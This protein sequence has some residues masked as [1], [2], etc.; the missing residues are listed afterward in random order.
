MSY[1]EIS[2]TEKNIEDSY[3][4]AIS[5][6]NNEELST[7]HEV[8]YSDSNKDLQAGWTAK[9]I[10]K[11]AITVASNVGRDLED[12]ANLIKEQFVVLSLNNLDKDPNYI[13]STVKYASA[14]VQ[15]VLFSD[16]Y[17]DMQAKKASLDIDN[18]NYQSITTIT[19]DGAK[20]A[21][22]EALLS[23]QINRK[24]QL[25]FVQKVLEV[26]K[27]EAKVELALSERDFNKKFER[28]LRTIAKYQSSNKEEF[29]YLQ[30]LV[31]ELIMTDVSDVELTLDDEIE[32]VY[33]ESV[34][35]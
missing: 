32:E 29:V 35:D 4:K 8:I 19:I 18:D 30:A 24:D 25:A 13:K 23:Q 2:H 6:A 33:N 5:K 16:K 34:R 28:S 26:G 3:F 9:Y 21:N 22:A 31:N 11:N 1:K 15:S 7:L 10:R 27:D 17:K 20:R 14:Y 12:V